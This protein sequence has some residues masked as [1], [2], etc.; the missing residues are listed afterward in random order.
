[1]VEVFSPPPRVGWWTSVIPLRSWRSV[2]FPNMHRVGS[3]LVVLALLQSAA[4]AQPPTFGS[5]YASCTA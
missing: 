5:W 2:H 1:M 3:F 4:L